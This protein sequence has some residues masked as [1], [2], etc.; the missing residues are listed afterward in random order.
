MRV[1]IDTNIFISG[2]FFGGKLRM[3]L[4]EIEFEKIQACFTT[5]TFGELSQVLIYQKFKRE[6]ALLSFS[7][8]EYL[9][10]LRAR[11]LFYDASENFPAVIPKDPADDAFLACAWV[12]QAAT[13]ISGDQ[14]L[15]RLKSFF[16]IPILSPEQF[17]KTHHRE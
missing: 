8:E 10:M 13:I 7:V 3:I 17:L 1:V 2:L 6:R 4:D 5:V 9:D 16:N 11:I 14:H 12:A 15:L